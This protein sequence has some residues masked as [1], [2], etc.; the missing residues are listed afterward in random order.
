MNSIITR[1]SFFVATMVVLAAC[2][3]NDDIKMPPASTQAGFTVELTNNGFYPCEARFTN[4]SLNAASYLW[5]F[6]D[7]TTSTEANPVITYAGPGIYTVTLS[8][9]G[10]NDVYY[11]KL[12][13]SASVNVKDP[14]A[15][16]T[17]VM[18]FTTRGADGGN[19]Y[20]VYLDSPDPQPQ[21][22]NAVGLSRPYGMAVDTAA[23]KVYVSDYA[24]GAIYRFNADGTNQTTFL[25]VN[26]PGQEAVD[27]PHGLLVIDGKVYWGRSGGIWMAN[28]D[29]TGI[30]PF[31]ETGATQP[32][33]PLDLGYDA[34]QQ[35]IYLVN[36]KYDFTGGVFSVNLDGTGLTK[37]VD[38][39]DGTALDLD[40]EGGKMYATL[41]ALDGTPFT[42]DG[43]YR[44]NLDGSSPAKIGDFGAKATWGVA[45]DR[46]TGFLYWSY[47]VSNSN[48]DGKIIRA[49]AD[50]S[51][52]V[53]W[54]TDVSPHA[55]VITD[56]KL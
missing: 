33:F 46:K 34:D 24:N 56:M 14:D 38:G 18:Y 35:K 39:V 40:T 20:M 42:E 1:L 52:Q 12:V 11:S 10:V 19:V 54:I 53:D 15:G 45:F 4:N 28:T 25:D 48:P 23:R 31:L 44:M 13:K 16:K 5:D 29:G 2:S 9:K 7:G 3:K 22:F 26:V 17:H 21:S 32:E 36:D 49:N 27:Y 8:C 43:L 47:K 30:V 51:G 37:L 6:G 55:M 50:G 41:Y